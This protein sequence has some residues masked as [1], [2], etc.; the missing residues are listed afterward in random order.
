[1]TIIGRGYHPDHAWSSRRSRMIITTIVRDHHDD[2]GGSCDALVV[3]HAMIMPMSCVTMRD[4]CEDHQGGIAWIGRNQATIE[5][6]HRDQ[7]WR[8]SR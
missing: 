7:D 1:M 2:R 5:H 8:S 4:P 3:C 6:D